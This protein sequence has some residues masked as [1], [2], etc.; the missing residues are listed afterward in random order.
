MQQAHQ[1]A[2]FKPFQHFPAGLVQRFLQP[3]LG[4]VPP[5]PRE[6]QGHG[7]GLRR[8]IDIADG[9]GH[10]FKG[11]GGAVAEEHGALDDVDQ[12]AHIARPGVRAQGVHCLLGDA[13]NL[14]ADAGAEVVDV[15]FHQH[16]DVL[17]AVPQRR[18]LERHNAQAVKQILAEVLRLHLFFQVAVG[19]GHH[20]HVHLEG[21]LAAH[22]LYFM[23]LQHVQQLH[24]ELVGELADFIEKDGPAVRQLKPSPP[25]A[26]RPG[27]GALLM[28][29]EL[30]FQQ[31]LRQRPAVDGDERTL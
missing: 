14:A 26:N 19:G 20:P 3:H 22:P 9:G 12:L 4:Q 5:V 29:V 8:F 18:D 27:K 21:F 7:V 25:R 15:A 16:R 31:G 17:A 30:A 1:V 6:R 2:P 28:A 13:V 10:V 11:D 23:L 24:L